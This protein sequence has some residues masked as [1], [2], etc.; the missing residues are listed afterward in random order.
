M[1]KKSIKN[2]YYA[3]ISF[4]L[5]TLLTI[6]LLFVDKSPIGVNGTIVGF[7]TINGFLHNL[8]GVHLS[9]YLIT[10]WLGLIPVF[11]CLGF[12]VL[13]LI[14]WIK[15]GSIKKVD[16]SLLVLGAFYIITFLIYMLF[17]S[18]IINYRPILIN[19]FLEVSYPSSTTIL[20][21]SFMLTALMQFNSRIKNKTFK[22]ILSFLIYS[23]TIFMVVGRLISG[24]HW[25]TDIVGG[26]LISAC[27]LF[28]YKG[29]IFLTEQD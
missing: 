27:L 25:F 18:I 17:N 7:S 13:G 20:S 6:L 28:L 3:L 23:F 16:F 29:V 10:D 5:F 14:E 11:I 26:I 24:V 8:F 19:G 12:A 15:Q 4:I 9:L 21:L 1:H 2:F 22:I